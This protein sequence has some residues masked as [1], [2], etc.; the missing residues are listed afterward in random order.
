MRVNRA[1]IQLN[2]R[3]TTQ[4]CQRYASAAAAAAA[5]LPAS[6]RGIGVLGME[7]YGKLSLLV[8]IRTENLFQYLVCGILVP[9]ERLI[10]SWHTAEVLDAIG[11]LHFESTPQNT[12]QTD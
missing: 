5:S 7:Y 1:I 10:E 4:Y 2:A 9:S 11:G 6:D 3:G 8:N 12:G